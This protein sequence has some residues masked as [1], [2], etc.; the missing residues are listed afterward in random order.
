MADNVQDADRISPDRLMW[1]FS[2]SPLVLCLIVAIIAHAAL[3]GATSV[4]YIHGLIDPDWKKEQDRLRKELAAAKALAKAIEE[5]RGAATRPASAPASK[6]AGETTHASDQD[7]M[8]M[9]KHKDS[10]VVRSA[11]SLPKPGEIPS[12]PDAI[13]IPPE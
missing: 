6:A 1:G 2:R 9:E 10:E 11:T 13:G 12:D 3:I 4:S 5:G 7:R 8:M